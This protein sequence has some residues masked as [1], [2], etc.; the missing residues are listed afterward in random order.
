MT[1]D[2]IAAKAG[3]QRG[4]L[5]VLVNDAVITSVNDFQ[6]QLATFRSGERVALT[7]NRDQQL[8]PVD[9]RIP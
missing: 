4:D 5:I 3:L 6:Q 1:R 9:F 8:L 7:I 2:S